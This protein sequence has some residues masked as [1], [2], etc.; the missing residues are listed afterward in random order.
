MTRGWQCVSSDPLAARRQPESLYL[1]RG[2]HAP[3]EH[4]SENVI[5]GVDYTQYSSHAN[6]L[7]IEDAVLTAPG[8]ERGLSVPN[9]ILLGPKARQKRQEML[10]LHGRKRG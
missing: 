7:Y 10:P 1:P 6:R 8:S 9:G 3:L 2:S 4:L 5:F